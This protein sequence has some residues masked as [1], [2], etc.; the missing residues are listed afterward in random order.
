MNQPQILTVVF[1]VNTTAPAC[2]KVPC[3]TEEY[4]IFK[5]LIQLI[6]IQK[7][8][9]LSLHILVDNLSE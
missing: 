2:K 6:L 1:T 3:F 5:K 7:L 4:N 8:G 9:L